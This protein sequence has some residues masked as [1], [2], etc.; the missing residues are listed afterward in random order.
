MTSELNTDNGVVIIEYKLTDDS[1]IPLD[2]EAIPT[3]SIPDQD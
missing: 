1:A 2:T 3:E